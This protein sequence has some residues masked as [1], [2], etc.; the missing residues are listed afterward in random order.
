MLC[1][2]LF[3]VAFVLGGP[4]VLAPVPPQVLSQKCPCICD[5][6]KRGGRDVLSGRGNALQSLSR[7]RLTGHAYQKCQDAENRV[8]FQKIP[9]CKGK[10]EKKVVGGAVGG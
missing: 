3:K 6:R 5:L 7:Y 1:K 4:R 9:L 10:S 8:W 2:T